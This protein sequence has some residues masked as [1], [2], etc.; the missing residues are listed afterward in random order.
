[1]PR[2]PDWARWVGIA[3]TALAFV[4]A[5]ASPLGFTVL[6][7]V[8]PIAFLAYVVALGILMLREPPVEAAAR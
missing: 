1:M 2:R 3:A 8:A 5:V 7:A 6:D 4:Q